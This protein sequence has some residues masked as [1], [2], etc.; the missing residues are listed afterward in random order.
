MSE[1]RSLLVGLDLSGDY[2]QICCYNQKT[3]EPESIC[4]SSDKT[5]Y[6]IPSVLGVKNTTKDWVFGEEA[7]A[8]HE[9]G[10]GVIICDL[11]NKVRNREETE[12]FGVFFEGIPL[13]EKFLRKCLQLLKIYYPTNSILKLVVTIQDLS[14]ELKEGVYKALSNLGIE[15]DRAFVQNHTTSYQYY[16]L[17]QSK[18][19]WINDIG[20]FD[21]DEKGLIYKQIS[22]NRKTQPYMVSIEEKD[23]SDILNYKILEEI[24]DTD[25]LEYTFRNLAKNVL[26]KQVVTTLY[27]TGKG[28]DGNQTDHVLKE[29][30]AGRRVFKGQN[31][32]SKGACYRAM[33]LAGERK[34]GDFLFLGSDMITVYFYISAIYNAKPAEVVLA[35]PGTLWNEIDEKID[36]ILDDSNEIT[37]Y[38]K[39]IENGEVKT[40]LIPLEGLPK[41][42]NKTTRI[43]V[44]LRFIN[45]WAAVITVKDKGFGSFYPSSNRV[46]EK[47]ISLQMEAKE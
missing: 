34:L 46:W 45:K 18:E 25:K 16:A 43:Q 7:L 47:E 21:F 5:K 32:Y 29:L 4:A 10:K 31:L 8:L 13:L 37:L 12:I 44:R 38:V 22:I 20:L 19:L 33:D 3:L 30:C 1:Q 28:F 6:L 41:R 27:F 15:K 9:A 2:S 26:Y 17:S 23:F 35:K 14:E 24:E 39:N 36:F 11:L 42:P 40:C